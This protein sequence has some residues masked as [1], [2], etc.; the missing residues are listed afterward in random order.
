MEAAAEDIGYWY[1]SWLWGMPLIAVTVMLHAAG[2]V[3]VRDMMQRFIASRADRGAA[4]HLNLAAVMG[5]AAGL[6]TLLH[7]LE[8]SVWAAAYV[9]VL[10]ALPTPHVAMLYSVSA[11]TAYGHAAVFLTP[12]WQMLGALESLNGLILFGL[13]TAFLYGI[14]QRAW[15]AGGR[16]H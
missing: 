4:L 6:V 8:A 9:V 12:R 11:M 10:G 3:L 5:M 14:I 7:L 1:S 15:P 2:L 16:P 13:S